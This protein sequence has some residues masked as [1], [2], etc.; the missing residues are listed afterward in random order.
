MNSLRIL[1][2]D[3]HPHFTKLAENLLDSTFEVVGRVGDGCALFEA[4]LNLKPDVI[5][6]DISMPILNGCFPD[7]SY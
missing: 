4:A 6:T 3:D 7:G 2:A 1:L 5:L